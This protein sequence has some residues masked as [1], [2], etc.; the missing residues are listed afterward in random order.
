M[1]ADTAMPGQGGVVFASFACGVCERV[2]SV[3][4]FEVC[5]GAIGCAKWKR[6]KA[7]DN[8]WEISNGDG[9]GNRRNVCGSWCHVL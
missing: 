1:S 9:V 3:R 4:C 6:P 2:T 8:R 7:G 5:V